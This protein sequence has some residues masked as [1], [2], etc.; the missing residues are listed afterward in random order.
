ML[1]FFIISLGINEFFYYIGDLCI[2]DRII[3]V[4]M[5][6]KNKNFFDKN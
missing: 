5:N 6:K 3:K 2:Y 1:C 4:I